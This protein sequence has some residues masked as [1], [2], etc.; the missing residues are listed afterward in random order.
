MPQIKNEVRNTILDT[1]MDQTVGGYWIDVEQLAIAA[2]VSEY[3]VRAV[4]KTANH[5]CKTER[6][7]TLTHNGQSGTHLVT[8]YQT[9]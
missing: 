1:L 9:A 3:S 5:R 6:R 8:L 7:P 2:G 4:L